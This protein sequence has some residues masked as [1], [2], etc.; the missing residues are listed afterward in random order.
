MAR[1][2]CGALLTKPPL[3]PPC[4]PMQLPAGQP[5]LALPVLG[6]LVPL[7]LS[8]GNSECSGG[9]LASESQVAPAWIARCAEIWSRRQ[10]PPQPPTKASQILLIYTGLNAAWLPWGKG[11]C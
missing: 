4:L 5:C 8:T 10:F 3:R 2:R 9:T 6:L 1:A 11:G 7:A